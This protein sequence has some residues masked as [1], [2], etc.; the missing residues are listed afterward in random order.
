MAKV[1]INGMGRIGRATLKILSDMPDLEIVAVNDLIPLDNIVYLLRYD[2]VYRRFAHPVDHEGDTLRIAGSDCRYFSEK[3]PA[4]LPWKELGIDLVF[5]CT[6]VFRQREM[7]QKHLQAGAKQ[8][9][10]SAPAKS[11][12]IPFVVHGVN[13]A[14]E[15]AQMISCASCTTNC[16]APV[17]EVVDRE[18][19]IRKAI[20]T[21]IHAYTAS[22][23]LVDGPR[24]TWT[25]GRAAAANF[26][27]TSTGAAQATAKAL[28]RM[29]GDFRKVT[30]AFDQ[31]Q[32]EA[33]WEYRTVR[34]K[35]GVEYRVPWRQ[36][37]V[38]TFMG[39]RKDLKEQPAYHYDRRFPRGSASGWGIYSYP[40][41][42]PG[43]E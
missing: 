43:M 38:I 28:P 20:M 23:S 24:N 22:Q 34:S 15:D 31:L 4:E 33:R 40:K 6:G 1:A 27:P 39:N 21:T 7:L 11:E 29:K 16:I 5:E 41:A 13:R 12:G 10:L 25:R 9:L 26:V 17:V 35:E 36:Y 18:I 2:T 3:D 32:I 19:G 14:D 42:G 30:V 8:V 37:P